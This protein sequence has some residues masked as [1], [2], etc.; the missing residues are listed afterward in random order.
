MIITAAVLD[1]IRTGFQKKFADAFAAARA[2]SFYQEVAT[3]VPSTAASETYGWLGDFP[4]MREWIGDRVIKD[5]KEQG[6][7]IANKEW[8]STVGVLRPHIED[9]NL[10]VYAPMVET[11]G[12]SAGNHPDRLIAALIKGGGAATCYD[13][14]YFFDTDHPVYANH[15]GT[16]AAT[17]VSNINSA[18]GANP[19]WYLLDCS[20]PLRPF[21]FQ[22][23]K[24]PELESKTDPSSS[25]TVFMSN[26]FVYGAYAR[27]NVG[28]GF[29]QMAYASNV[30]LDGTSLDAAIRALME[31]K[32]DGGRP[33]GITPTH[34]IVPPAYR[35]A[36]MRAVEVQ[37][38]AGGGSNPNYKAVKPL[39]V[40]WLA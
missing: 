10:G 28:Y 13:G 22:E 36:A 18:G 30:A 34:L 35:S 38:E 32:A 24:K 20:K 21:I 5:M 3:T 8:E 17:S 15:D 14:Q 11:M 4:D 6:Y 40:P 1:A 33:L 39:I 25:D 27:H 31:V 12:Q 37:L 23:R 9:D 7:T 29:W 19:Y 26:K 2:A 16:G